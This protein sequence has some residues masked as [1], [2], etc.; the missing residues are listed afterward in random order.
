MQLIHKST[1]YAAV[2]MYKQIKI[3]IITTVDFI[4]MQFVYI[5]VVIHETKQI[6]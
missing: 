2:Y 5:D 1:I 3:T 4:S 6:V